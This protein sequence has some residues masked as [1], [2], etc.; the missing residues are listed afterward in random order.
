MEIK[1]YINEDKYDMISWEDAPS[2]VKVGDLLDYICE[3]PEYSQFIIRYDLIMTH[4]QSGGFVARYE[5]IT[6][7]SVSDYVVTIG[8]QSI[9]AQA[10]LLESILILSSDLD[11]RLLLRKV[12][13]LNSLL[14]NE[15]YTTQE[16]VAISGGALVTY[17]LSC[18]SDK[19]GIMFAIGSLLYTCAYYERKLNT[20]KNPKLKRL[21]IDLEY[22]LIAEDCIVNLD[23][24]KSRVL[25]E[26]KETK[27]YTI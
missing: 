5:R 7:E 15:D 11:S 8:P 17:G 10:K 9:K 27:C 3:L 2:E 13:Y 24:S 19:L 4:I 14:E 20:I 16:L 1:L 21:Q 18:L 25:K 23:T 22:S 6:A 26:I 12:S